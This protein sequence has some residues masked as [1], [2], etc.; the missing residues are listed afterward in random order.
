MAQPDG[1]ILIDTSIITKNIKPKVQEIEKSLQQIGKDAEKAKEKLELLDKTGV[2]HS[3]VEYKEA[4]AELGK[5][6]DAYRDAV[7]DIAD[8]EKQVSDTLVFDPS[9]IDEAKAKLQTLESSGVSHS[10][11][12]YEE[13]ERE[14]KHLI[15]TQQRY[16]DTTSAF[17]ES[18]GR[19]YDG[20]KMLRSE[21]DRYLQTLNGTREAAAA[22]DEHLNLLRIDVEEYAKSLQELQD[23]GK[24]FGDEEYDRVYLAWKNA[25]DA[26]KAYQ[27]ELNKQT[28]TG[29][30]KEAERAAK[31]EKALQ[32]ENARLQREA[33]SEAKLQTKA[34]ER[35]AKLEA[36]TAE[37]ER[38]AQIRENAVVG[39]QHIVEVIER[40]KQLMQ[41][42]ADLEKAGVTS[43]YADYDKRQKELVALDQEIK[44]Y[45][46]DI[47]KTKES[48]KK[49]GDMAKQSLNKTISSVKKFGS[50][51]K[52]AFGGLNKSAKKSNG[53]LT[54]LGAR[55][56]SL[57]MSLL[58]FNQIGKM[59]GKM[60]SAIKTGFKNIYN[61]SDSFKKTVDE[62]KASVLTLKNTFA[63]A[64][65]PIVNIAIPYIKQLI[66]WLTKA[67]DM[68]AQ[69]IAALAGQKTYKK[70]VEQT[71]AAIE[72]E[73]DAINKQLSPL[74]KLNNL[75]S[76][77]GASTGAVAGDMFE[78]V[79]I[80]DKWKDIA[81]W[82]KDMWEASDFYELGKWLGDKLAETLANIP[83]EKIKKNARKIGSSL[84]TLIN[85]FIEGEFDG[86][87]VGLW[88]G[89]TLA[90]AINTGFEFFNEFVHKLNWDSVGK[91][92]ADTL[93]GFFEGIDWRLI[94]DTFV[95]GFKGLADSINSFIHSFHW[96]DLSETISNGINIAAETIYTFFSTTEWD[97]LGE[98]FGE[99]LRKSI[100][101]IEW[102]EVGRALGS[103]VQAALD[104]LL[105][106]VG[107]Q[108]MGEI[109]QAIIDTLKGFFEVVD[110][111][112]LA[113]VVLTIIA[114]NLALK[115]AGFAFNS[116]CSAILSGLSGAF[117]KVVGG[118]SAIASSILGGISG[119]FTSLGG[120]GAVLTA[121]IGTVVA[122]RTLAEV[123]VMAGTGVI[124]GII[125][126]FAGWN[127]GQFL[128]E[129][130]TGEQIEMSF[131]EQVKEI[132][133]SFTDGSWVEAF[134]MWGSDIVEGLK[135][136]ITDAFSAIGSWIDEH[137]FQPFVNCFK[138]LFGIHSP[139]TV[140]EGMGGYIIEGLLNGLKGKW[141]SI[142]EWIQDKIQWIKDMFSGL[143][144][145]I[146][147][148]FGKSGMPR[149]GLAG[150]GAVSGIMNIPHPVIASLQNV[151]LPAYAT[152]QV[153]PRTMKRHLAILG[154][155]DSET[156]IVSPLSTM[157][158]A[159][160]ESF[161]EVLS[162]LGILG[163]NSNSGGSNVYEFNEDGQVFFRIME[164]YVSEYKKQHG[165]RSPF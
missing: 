134:K 23:Q 163:R 14:L 88:I 70:A 46:D 36:E 131:T 30:A 74:D 102:E 56:K 103:I 107:E 72:D 82:F 97:E 111:G 95:T 5:L 50:F 155:N 32:K 150:V 20:F 3:S 108:D 55:F 34:A 96:D 7:Y 44:K 98:N 141:G 127:F 83:W 121:D 87:S 100:E 21:T 13:T 132:F 64:F 138:E 137:I 165:G 94:R 59:F 136:G 42:I 110:A 154:D 40:R 104:F 33:E 31:A 65:L 128:Y 164:K 159:N 27:T 68:F 115:A 29:Q 45:R 1:S 118:F 79:P 91:F 19:A 144:S 58:I 147:S 2:S 106:F 90:E 73:T 120:L 156:E 60:S 116:A 47:G 119:A 22:E 146:S 130:I 109:A 11:K 135:L 77:S 117:A 153:I 28:E 51:V 12:E 8:Y 76:D 93:N 63:A 41:E 148:F 71:T 160:K 113:K 67:A 49:L 125:A 129:K 133:K 105:S 142:S 92:I 151:E 6:V 25:A 54:N 152:G 62:L 114:S 122:T 35:Q 4:Q 39:N 48:Y 84:A 140:M 10:D 16:Q 80:S 61:G 112:D 43:G 38:L 89:H 126:A 66:S 53:L 161:L 162:D 123:G 24:F 57:A 78:D 86:K 99:Q 157:K 75:S 101:K 15:D 52:N 124:G 9:K 81:Q 158:Q 149:A 145:S 26:V 69:F 143:G 139:S 37:E 85:G 18:T 17:I